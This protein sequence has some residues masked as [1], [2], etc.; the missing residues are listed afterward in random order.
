MATVFTSPL[1]DVE[2]P[3]TTITTLVFR[4]ASR[5]ADRDAIID[6]L[7]GQSYTFGQL[8]NA[9]RRSAGGL[10]ARGMSKGDIVAIL[11][12][13]LPEYAI[14][15]HAVATVGGI[16]TTINP[17]YTVAEITTHLADSKAKLIFTIPPLLE[18]AKAAAS[19]TGVEGIFVIGDDEGA[20]S[21]S[22]LT[23]TGPFD[24]DPDIDPV[25]DVVVLPYSSG[26]TGHPKGVQLTH[27]NLVANL[28]Q[29]EQIT[30]TNE[31]D[32]ILAVLPFFHIYGMQVL[33]NGVLHMGAR[34]I[35]MPFFDL[36]QF[37][38]LIQD[39]RVTRVAVVP[40]IVLALAKSPLVDKYDLSSLVQIGSGAAPLSAEVEAE[41]MRRTG[42]QVVQGFGLTET[43]PVTH[44]M[45]PDEVRSGSIGV[46]IP[47][48][49]I[50]VV[51]PQTG[52]DLGVGESGELWIRGPQVM[53]GYLNDEEATRESI[54]DEGWLRTGD[55]GHVDGDGF[56]YITD[57]IKELIKYKG[58]QVA[59][60][61]LEAVLLTH[62]A[63]VDA[64]VIGVADR[65]AGEIPKGFVVL[66]PDDETTAEQIMTYVSERVAGYKQI[67]RI[68]FIDAIPKS[69]SGKILRRVLRERD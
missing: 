23:A 63:V 29:Y 1:P 26:T 55:V 37:L 54:D 32:V 61:E 22:E 5:L 7:S 15:F 67:R 31:N 62:P 43:S 52:D 4:H 2:I 57:R 9:V 59:P 60:A 49:E 53:K 11:C 3:A 68:E 33:M 20:I 48:T 8:Q 27:R 38:R 21:L 41:A 45:P 69:P 51:D 6:G 64:A 18:T 24:G 30:T 28:A 17:S 66:R 10:A 56:W 14:V 12:P 42:A 40:P 58:F 50:R 36:E 47:N 19:A 34:T 35:T 39:H 16:V 13:N 25:D 44:A 46:P 65:E